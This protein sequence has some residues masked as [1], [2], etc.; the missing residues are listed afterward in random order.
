MVSLRE[1]S[2]LNSSFCGGSLISD[3]WI[4]TAGHC[5][6]Y[7]SDIT[8]VIGVTDFL[9]ETP[10]NFYPVKKTLKHPLH[11]II[12]KDYDFALIQLTEPIKLS[13][14]I[15]IIQLAEPGFELQAGSWGVFTGW[16]I[17]NYEEQNVPTR[18]QRADLIAFDIDACQ[19][20]H[21]AIDYNITD[22]ML[23]ATF[24]GG[25]VDQCNGDSGGPLVYNGKQVGTSSWSIKPCGRH[26]FPGVMGKVSSATNWIREV[27]SGV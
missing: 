12:P 15:A 10:D 1:N 7:S 9:D 25:G 5:I 27:I 4:L 6:D 8:A 20:I 11:N 3:Q 22:S 23:C 16:G 2:R 21:S 19:L 26:D 17:Y 14:T 24:P 18:L 13:D